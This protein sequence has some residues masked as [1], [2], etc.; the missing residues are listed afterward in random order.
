MRL[1]RRLV[2]IS[3]SHGDHTFCL[4]NTL[5]CACAG[6]PEFHIHSGESAVIFPRPLA[7]PGRKPIAMVATA[8]HHTAAVTTNGELYTWGSNRD[9][10][11]GYPAVD[12]QPV[13]RR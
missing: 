2:Q 6:H 10:R 8:K 11:L 1:M 5:S 4:P 3:S 13:P 12:T 7:I 9:G